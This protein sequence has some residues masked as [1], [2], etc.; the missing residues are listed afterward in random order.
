MVMQR[1]DWGFKG[2][3]YQVP[4][5]CDGSGSRQQ[6]GRCHAASV[7]PLKLRSECSQEAFMKW[8]TC[9]HPKTHEGKRFW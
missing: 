6:Q 9:F 5:N 2:H 1:S 3:A 4:S 7:L 8:Y